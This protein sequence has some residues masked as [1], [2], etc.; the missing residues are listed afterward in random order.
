MHTNRHKHREEFN[1]NDFVENSASI[2]LPK[3][4]LPI[5]E[6]DFIN[7]VENETLLTSSVQTKHT[8]KNTDSSL[9]SQDAECSV[10]QIHKIDFSDAQPLQFFNVKSQDL[11]FIP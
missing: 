5:I 2:E 6:T 9:V 11:I 7:A 4:T 1:I 10:F 3:E 8:V